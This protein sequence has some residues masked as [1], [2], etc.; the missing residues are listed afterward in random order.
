MTCAR[1]ATINPQGSTVCASCGAPLVVGMAPPPP[2]AYMPPG[3]YMPPG[4]MPPGYGMAPPQRSGIPKT[5]GI[6]MIVFGS[7]GMLGTFGNLAGNQDESLRHLDAYQEL[8]KMMKI[9]AVGDIFIG[10]LHIFAGIRLA[11][12]KKNGP[13][14]AIVYAILRI[15]STIVAL[16]LVYAWLMPKL[17]TADAPSNAKALVSGIFVF[18]AIISTV[19][20]IIIMALVTRPA[21]KQACEAGV[22]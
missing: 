19:W 2:S 11:G 4:Y 21:A 18:A 1:C 13:M 3:G 8:M 12:Y 5:I 17:D 20:P 14:L 22:L 15:V 9:I 6:L 16:V 10:A 7:L